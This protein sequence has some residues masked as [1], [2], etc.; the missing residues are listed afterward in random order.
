MQRY[1]ALS[2]RLALVPKLEMPA[3]HQAVGAAS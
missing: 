3:T 2:P 1:F